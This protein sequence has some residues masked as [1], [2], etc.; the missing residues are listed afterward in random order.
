MVSSVVVSNLC[1]AG[2]GTAKKVTFS[3]PRVP[4]IRPGGQNELAKDCN[5][6]HW[7]ALKNVKGDLNFSF[8]GFSTDKDLS[9]GQSYYKIA[10]R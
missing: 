4:N 10:K 9:H 7:A 8:T 5:L 1:P 6:A 3:R 2:S